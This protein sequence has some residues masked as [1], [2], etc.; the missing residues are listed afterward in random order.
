MMPVR[1]R[2]RLTARSAPPSKSSP[3]NAGK[4]KSI[5]VDGEKRPTAVSFELFLAS[6]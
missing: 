1:F 2:T 4:E 5:L 6:S 3:E